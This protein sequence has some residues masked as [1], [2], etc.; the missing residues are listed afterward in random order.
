MSCNEPHHG[1]KAG[2]HA[3]RK[4]ADTDL[5]SQA[6]VTEPSPGVFG[7]FAAEW[8]PTMMSAVLGNADEA[9]E[10]GIHILLLD[11]CLTCLSW[12]ALFPAVHKAS[13]SLSPQVK[14]AA[15]ALMDYLVSWHIHGVLSQ[16]AA[17]TNAW[18]LLHSR[19]VQAMCGLTCLEHFLTFTYS[20][21]C[22]F[23]GATCLHFHANSAKMRAAVPVAAGTSVHVCGSVQVRAAYSPQRQIVNNNFNLIKA[24]IHHWRAAVPLPLPALLSLLGATPPKPSSGAPDARAKRKAAEERCVAMKLLAAGKGFLV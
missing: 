17:V 19:G 7:H 15:D 12:P 23:P 24:F 4:R 6:S 2:D 5:H 14:L 8:F 18:L 21:C 3:S 13:P 9:A 10:E 16:D 1:H 11:V 22:F 20:N